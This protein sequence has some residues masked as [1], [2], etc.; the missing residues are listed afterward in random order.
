MTEPSYYQ[1]NK[2]RIQQK[3]REWYQRNRQSVIER[4]AQWQKTNRSRASEIWRKSKLRL[5]Y[6]ITQEDFDAIL[7]N[8]D[9]KCAICHQDFKS[10]PHVDHCHTSGKVRGL[11]CKQCN[12]LIGY[13]KDDPAIL[14]SA[15]NYL[16]DKHVV[17]KED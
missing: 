9:G 16:R 5:K 8:Q 13:A 7:V 4:T 12:L 11:L 14:G 17:E 15:I 10:S 2:A 3:N 1:R 6:G